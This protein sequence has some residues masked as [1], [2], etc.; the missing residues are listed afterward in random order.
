MTEQ[1]AT[2]RKHGAVFVPCGDFEKVGISRNVKDRVLP[3]NGLR[4]KPE[5]GTSGWFLWAGEH[6]S[7]D[8]DFFVPLHVA[9]I[10][11]WCAPV[12]KFLGLPPGWRFLCAGDFEDVW[13]DRSLLESNR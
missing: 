10:E 2:C 6:M 8:P 12:V 9:H 1:E 3:I 13:E 7:D 5:S 11:D 4:L